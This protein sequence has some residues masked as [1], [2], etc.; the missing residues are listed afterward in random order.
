MESPKLTFAA[1]DARIEALAQFS[2]KTLAFPKIGKW[3]FPLAAVGA[4]FS[5]LCIAVLP[6]NAAYTDL[7]A[8]MGLS[9]EIAGAIFYTASQLPNKWP[10]F[11]NSRRA[12]AEKLD[13]D[14]PNHQALIKWLREFPM[15]DRERLK[16]F[17]S[18][19][20]ERLKERL[21]ML[22]GSIEKLGALPVIVALYLQFK[23]VRWPPHPSLLEIFLIFVL[24]FGY[25]QCVMQINVRLRL[26]LYETLLSK[27]L[28]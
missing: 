25:W 26:H 24:I 23:G 5:L 2:S 7:L 18:Y 11:A 19:R 14:M 27:A 20:H 4:L 9:V 28:T 3:G 21:P 1:L 8:H 15:Q 10:T 16:E 13:F 12:S 22:I 17:V 6:A